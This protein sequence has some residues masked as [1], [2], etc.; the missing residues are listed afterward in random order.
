MDNVL[1]EIEKCIDNDWKN[2]HEEIM[3]RRREEHQDKNKYPVIGVLL[4]FVSRFLGG[5]N[6]D[7]KTYIKHL[8]EYAL[9]G[10]Q[11]DKIRCAE[12]GHMFDFFIEKSEMPLWSASDSL[13][14][15]DSEFTLYDRVY[16]H[17]RFTFNCL[18]C[19]RSITLNTTGKILS[20]MRSMEENDTEREGR[21]NF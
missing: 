14:L 7:I 12:C 9:Y 5:R 16:Y 21:T 15:G 17:S 4:K 2:I 6:E 8:T 1:D 19:G 18:N 20:I 10:V 3:N 13:S 11:I